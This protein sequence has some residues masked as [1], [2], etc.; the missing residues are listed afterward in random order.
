MAFRWLLMPFSLLFGV[1]V[2]SRALAYRLRLIRSVRLPVPVIVVGNITT[3]GTGKTPLTLAL[4]DWLRDAG[5]HPGIVSRGHGGKVRAPMPVSADSDPAAVG[6]EPVLLARRAGCPVWVGRRRAEAGR[7]LLAFHPEVDVLLADDGLQHYTLARDVEI[8]VVD[9][10][11]G[12][13]NGWL[14]PAGPLRERRR[15]LDRVDALVSNGERRADLPEQAFTMQLVGQV[16]HHLR[17][18]SQTAS[19]RDLADRPLHAVAGIGHPQRFFDH[20]EALGLAF[21]PHAFPDHHGFRPGELPSGRVL[22][23]EK[24]AVKLLPRAG[25]PGLEDC[26]YLAVDAELEPGLKHLILSRIS[27]ERESHH[28]SQTA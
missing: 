1:I 18:P 4:V 19:A 14:L 23:T 13:G 20:L 17:V 28:G 3:G 21:T 7:Q 15:R 9:G 11:R 5:W 16:F 10:T 12:L 2:E 26:W 6:D 8:A 25:E 27:K 24:D 22:M